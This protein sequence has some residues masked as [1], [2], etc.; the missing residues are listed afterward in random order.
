[1]VQD[2]LDVAI[3]QIG[4]VTV[5]VV[6]RLKAA[7]REHAFRPRLV[8][9][10]H[11]FGHAFHPLDVEKDG[12][13]AGESLGSCLGNRVVSVPHTPVSAY[14]LRRA[15]GARRRAWR[16]EHFHRHSLSY[17]ANHALAAL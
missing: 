12:R 4:V 10:A 9:S 7:V 14:E 6:T 13:A 15:A 1:L 17:V 8:V 3:N 16:D 11:R 2:L 5:R